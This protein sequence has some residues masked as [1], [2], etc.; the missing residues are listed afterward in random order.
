[1]T[2]LQPPRRRRAASWEDLASCAGMGTNMFFPNESGWS[3]A[4]QAER[5]KAICRDCPVRAEC[6]AMAMA[7]ADLRGIWGGTTWHERKAAREV[8][9]EAARDAVRRRAARTKAPEQPRHNRR[10]AALVAAGDKER[11]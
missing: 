1:M 5:A 7:D 6:L 8:A 11:P 2:P 3:G 4:E 10:A 9:N